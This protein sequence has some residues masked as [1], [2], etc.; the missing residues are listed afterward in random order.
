MR[1]SGMA[2]PI[3]LPGP[4]AAPGASSARWLTCTVVSV[5]PYMLTRTGLSSACRAYQSP[6]R[7]RSSASPPKTTYRRHSRSPVAGFSR[8]ACISW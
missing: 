7:H 2:R 4:E 5:M 3:M 6:S 1:R 8:S